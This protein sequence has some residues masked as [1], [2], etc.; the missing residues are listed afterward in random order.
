MDNLDFDGWNNAD[1][2][3]VIARHH[4]DDVLVVWKGQPPT[5]GV[6][7]GLKL[8]LMPLSRRFHR[9]LDDSC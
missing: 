8:Q 4:T 1:W 7:T 6:F 2:N 3:G 9:R 5:H